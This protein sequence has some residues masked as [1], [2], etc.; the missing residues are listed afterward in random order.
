MKWTECPFRCWCKGALAHSEI[1]RG[2]NCFIWIHELLNISTPISNAVKLK[3]FTMQSNIFEQWGKVYPEQTLG[4]YTRDP[5]KEHGCQ[6]VSGTFFN[7]WKQDSAVIFIIHPHWSCIMEP[8]HITHVEQVMSNW[9]LYYE[10]TCCHR[11]KSMK[12]CVPCLHNEHGFIH[13]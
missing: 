6:I 5:G 9:Q 11:N 3:I 8:N 1:N 13:K 4:D 2:V 7:S 12:S 10:A